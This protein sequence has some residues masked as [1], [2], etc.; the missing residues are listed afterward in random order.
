MS[1]V[2]WAQHVKPDKGVRLLWKQLETPDPSRPG[3]SYANLPRLRV[4]PASGRAS[5]RVFRWPID[6]RG[7][8][9]GKGTGGWIVGLGVVAGPHPESRYFAETIQVA[10]DVAEALYLG[11]P[12]PGPSD[13]DLEDEPDEDSLESQL[14]RSLEGRP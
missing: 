10:V 11:R 13:P 12:L 8:P 1:D 6:R 5:S 2:R 4:D 14:K 7:R 9:S 3:C